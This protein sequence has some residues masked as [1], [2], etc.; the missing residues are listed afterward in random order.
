MPREPDEKEAR[1]GAHSRARASEGRVASSRAD[2][3]AQAREIQGLRRDGTSRRASRGG[4]AGVVAAVGRS[5]AP[6]DLD[7][8]RTWPCLRLSTNE[9]GQK[10][11]LH[12]RGDL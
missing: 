6:G 5:P 10:A 9:E 4:V 11:L 3:A 8:R 1:A 12:G 7:D 2:Q